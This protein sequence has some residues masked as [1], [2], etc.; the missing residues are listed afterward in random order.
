MPASSSRVPSTAHRNRSRAVEDVGL[1]VH[2][3]AIGAG[4]YRLEIRSE[5]FA[6]C[7]L[8]DARRTE[9]SDNAFDVEPGGIV[10][11]DAATAGPLRARVR[12]VNATDAVAC[13]AEAVAP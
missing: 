6:K 12:A 2:A 11:V 7:V 1:A 13:R 8:I 5:R 9:L 3:S 4:R 10:G